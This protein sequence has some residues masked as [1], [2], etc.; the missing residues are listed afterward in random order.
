[1]R[2][3]SILPLFGIAASMVHLVI[4]LD[5]DLPRE[6]EKE[7]ALTEDFIHE[8][9]IMRMASC[10]WCLDWCAFSKRPYVR[11][12]SANAFKIVGTRIGFQSDK[13]EQDVSRAA[14]LQH[15]RR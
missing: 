2:P 10:H 7:V 1:M 5:Y 13:S 15:N 8:L 9:V 4:G 12:F 11:P 6:V 14:R 3:F